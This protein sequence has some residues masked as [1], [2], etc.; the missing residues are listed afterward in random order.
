MDQLRHVNNV[1]YADYLQEARIDFFRALQLQVT[2][3]DPSGAGH[4]SDEATEEAYGIVVVRHEMT[5]LAP[6][7]FESR[8]VSVEIWVTE[9]RAASFTVGYEIFHDTDDGSRVVYMRATT[10][11]AQIGRA[12]V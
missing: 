12:H 9:V 4:E 2:N 8:P 1:R 5:Y 6:L 3:A 11:L 10:R 7:H